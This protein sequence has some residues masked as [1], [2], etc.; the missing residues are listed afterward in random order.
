MSNVT[1]HDVLLLLTERMDRLADNQRELARNQQEL[2]D[3]TNHKIDAVVQM[4]DERITFLH[5][6]LFDVLLHKLVRSKIVW[7]AL[8]ALAVIMAPVVTDHWH[9]LLERAGFVL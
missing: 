7:A 6:E 9:M 5:D 1:L 8:A 3:A 2:I 4:M